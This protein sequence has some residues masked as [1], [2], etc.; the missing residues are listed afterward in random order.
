MWRKE[1]AS[2]SYTKTPSSGQKSPPENDGSDAHSELSKTPKNAKIKGFTNIHI[3]TNNTPPAEK[4]PEL[5][6]QVEAKQKID[7]AQATPEKK[8]E[9]REHVK[10][11]S[12]DK[13]KELMTRIEA[14][15]QTPELKDHVEK[16]THVK[17]VLQELEE[18]AKK[19][20]APAQQAE[21]KP[22]DDAK[23]P[24]EVKREESNK[25]WFAGIM[26]NPKIAGMVGGLIRLFG[27]LKKTPMMSDES[28]G[29]LTTVETYYQDWFA[30]TEIREM[31]Q[32]TID[33]TQSLKDKLT[34]VPGRADD[35]A[36]RALV[37]EWKQ[38]DSPE[39]LLAFAQGKFDAFLRDNDAAIKTKTKLPIT[40][41]SLV[42]KQK[43]AI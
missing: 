40:L 5:I 18:E 1:S 25:G 29:K 10:K 28:K 16:E 3:E 24:E 41:Q 32:Q 2:G 21:Y 37:M 9:A 15:R 4:Q 23:T 17:P 13:R 22:A 26:E 8:N 20:D 14:Y 38:S 33:G 31:V 35:K 39:P 12:A 43:L 6:K 27:G 11:M 19:T 30:K 42:G 34:L 7:V 36:M